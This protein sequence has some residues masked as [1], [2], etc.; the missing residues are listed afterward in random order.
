MK[1]QNIF[2]GAPWEARVGYCRAVRIGPFVCVSGT[3][4]TDSSGR[5]VGVGDPYVQAKETLLKIRAA[6][7]EAGVTLEQVVRTRM[8]VTHIADWEQVAKAHHEFFGNI[9]PATTMVEVSRLIAPEMLV[10]IEADAI[11]QELLSEVPAAPA[12]Y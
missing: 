6:L 7:H 1:R 12:T 3:T 9:Y 8:Y 2:S 11:V 10:E 4:A 5:V